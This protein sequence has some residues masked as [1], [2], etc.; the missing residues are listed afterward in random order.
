[1]RDRCAH[2]RSRRLVLEGLLGHFA[3]GRAHSRFLT[4]DGGRGASRQLDHGAEAPDDVLRTGS[5]VN[6]SNTCFEPIVSL[7]IRLERTR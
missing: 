7:G 4:D 1:M 3:H 6:G 2:S 5:D